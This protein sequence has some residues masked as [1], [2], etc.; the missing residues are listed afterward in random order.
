MLLFK[1]ILAFFWYLLTD[2]LLKS[3]PN[4]RPPR[5]TTN[6]VVMRLIRVMNPRTIVLAALDA[7]AN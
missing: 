7:L 1:I 2:Q 5:H 3:L 6:G 4:G